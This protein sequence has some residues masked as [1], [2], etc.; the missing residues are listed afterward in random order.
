ME[1]SRIDL[2]DWEYYGEGGSSTSYIYKL[3]GNIVLKLNNNAVPV[4]NTVREYL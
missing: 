2:K 1:A 3:D 4:E